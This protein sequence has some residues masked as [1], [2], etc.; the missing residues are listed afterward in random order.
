MTDLLS[1]QELATEEEPDVSPETSSETA[2]TNPVLAMQKMVGN[3]A[4]VSMFANRLD[5]SSREFFEKKMANPLASTLLDNVPS[6]GMGKFDAKYDVATGQLL[7]TVKIHFAF[8]GTWKPADQQQFE[9]RFITQVEQGWSGKYHFKCTK[10][11]FTD[12]DVVPLVSVQTVEKSKAHYVVEVGSGPGRAMVGREGSKPGQQSGAFFYKDD[13]NPAPHQ[14]GNIRCNIAT[15][16]ATR[17]ERV[18]KASGARTIFFQKGS[19][20]VTDVSQVDKVAQEILADKLPGAPKVPLIAIG[21][22]SKDEAGG[23]LKKERNLDKARATAVSSKLKAKMPG[24]NVKVSTNREAAAAAIQEAKGR[25]KAKREETRKKGEQDLAKAKSDA[26]LRSDPGM[27]KVELGVDQTFAQTFAGDPYSVAVHE[28]GHMLGNPDEYYAWGPK[29]L[30]QKVA[31]LLASGDPQK[32]MEGVNLDQKRKAGKV[33]ASTTGDREDIQ[34]D[35]AA[36]VSSAGLEIPYFGSMNSSLMSAGTDLLPRH[37]V[38]L[39]EALG[40]ITDPTISRSEW[41]IV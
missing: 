14:S 19:V 37:Y 23:F 11:G 20:T 24:Y 17:M 21:Y 10:A 4:T 28:F 6:T 39:W 18:L 3:S 12:L 15:H 35:Y 2:S 31:Q 8:K 5:V 26:K 25:T 27:R 32:M 30:D 1:A 40:R 13:V 16:E 36:L 33:T 9:R 29:T 7:I 38:A 22:I 41:K 34:S